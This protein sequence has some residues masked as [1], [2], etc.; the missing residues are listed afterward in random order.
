MTTQMDDPF[1]M[2]STKAAS[3]LSGGSVSAVFPREGFTHEGTI[4]SFRMAQRTDR[5]SGELLFWEGKKTVEQSKLVF[6]AN[7]QPAEQLIVEIQGQPSGITWE[8]NQY[9]E[10]AVPDDDGVRTLYIKGG[11][12]KAIAKAMRDAGVRAPEINGYLKI[13]RGKDI[14]FGD[15]WGHSHVAVYTPAAQNGAAAGAF[16]DQNGAAPDPFGGQPAQVP[17]PFGG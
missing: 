5:D 8:T 4:L 11:M 12:Q 3:F 9:R 16:L 6:P 15:N 2:D 7:A 14:K 17:D 13:T 1:S 10:K